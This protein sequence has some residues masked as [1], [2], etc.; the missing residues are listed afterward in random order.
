M[1]EYAQTCDGRVV[2]L[3]PAFIQQ[4]GYLASI[5][6]SCT[7]YDFIPIPFSSQ[8]VCSLQQLTLTLAKRPLILHTPLLLD[9]HQLIRD[10]WAEAGLLG[11][12]ALDMLIGADFLGA[13]KACE[14]LCAFVAL[15]FV[16]V[17]GPSLT[18]QKRNRLHAKFPWAG[19]YLF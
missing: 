14:F 4:C 13:L 8:T 6:E 10:L 1:Q 15:E 12:N 7:N 9:D 11:Q 19:S 16:K 3:E 17:E 2:L 5:T 18:K